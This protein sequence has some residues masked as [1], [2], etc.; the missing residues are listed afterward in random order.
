MRKQLMKYPMKKTF[1]EEFYGYKN[2]RET[3][4]KFNNPTPE[5]TYVRILARC[6]GQKRTAKELFPGVKNPVMHMVR[7]MVREGLLERY[8][9]GRRNYYFTTKK[10]F[11]LMV[12][13][14]Q[15]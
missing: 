12:E 1:V 7:D 5:R 4:T 3:T 15:H 13:A 9:D 14:C 8:T 6:T 10:G 2:Y 11:D